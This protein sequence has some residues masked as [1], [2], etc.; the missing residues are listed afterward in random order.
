MAATK[1]RTQKPQRRD[2]LEFGSPSELFGNLLP[3]F[4]IEYPGISEQQKDNAGFGE[5]KKL[6]YTDDTLPSQPAVSRRPRMRDGKELTENELVDLYRKVPKGLRGA[7]RDFMIAAAGEVTEVRKQATP[8]PEDAPAP[9]PLKPTTTA[10]AHAA[11]PRP[12]TAEELFGNV[13][14]ALQVKAHK[15]YDFPDALL[16]DPEAFIAARRIANARNYRVKNHLPLTAEED[17]Q[18]LMA[19][20][21]VNQARS[22]QRRKRG[23]QPSST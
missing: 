2:K 1:T 5:S 18:G 17:A 23:N 13:P 22:R 20:S 12:V 3:P 6:G 4:P 19:N 21:F 15:K 11:A 14:A 7:V 16:D 8:R 10:A 9:A